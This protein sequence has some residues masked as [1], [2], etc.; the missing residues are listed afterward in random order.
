MKLCDDGRVLRENFGV[1][2]LPRKPGDGLLP[3]KLGF[4]T[5]SGYARLH[6]QVA[7]AQS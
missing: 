4:G 7:S 3:R 1:G 5:F 2:L 6:V